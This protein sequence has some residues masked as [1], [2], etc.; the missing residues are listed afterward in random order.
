MADSSKKIELKCGQILQIEIPEN[1]S[2]GYIWEFTSK[3]NKKILELVEDKY[4]DKDQK[5]HALGQGNRRLL[6]FKSNGMGESKV[7]LKHWRP[8]KGESN[9]LHRFSV[10]VK[11]IS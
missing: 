6:V 9:I 1:L 3:P 11:V 8:W 4:L 10:V 2:T 7:E 5:P